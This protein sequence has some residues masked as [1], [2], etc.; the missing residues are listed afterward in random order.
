MNFILEQSFLLFVILRTTYTI[1]L[2]EFASL[3]SWFPNHSNWNTDKNPLFIAGP[4]SAETPEQLMETCLEIAKNEKVQVL[5]AGIWKPR[6]RPNNFEGVG[7]IGLE[8]L[9][10]V[11]KATGKLNYN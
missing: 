11:K 5:R 1:Y 10:D 9:L 2:M 4:C 6:T 3:S 7:K 8:W